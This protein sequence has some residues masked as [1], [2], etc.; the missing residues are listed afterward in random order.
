[1]S[2]AATN[3]LLRDHKLGCAAH[4]QRIVEGRIEFV[5][6][7]RR[8]TCRPPS[9]REVRREFYQALSALYD[10]LGDGLSAGEMVPRFDRARRAVDAVGVFLVS[11]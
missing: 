8:C 5:L 11:R 2:D 10:G 3:H 7:E 9:F 6:D 4:R 1:M